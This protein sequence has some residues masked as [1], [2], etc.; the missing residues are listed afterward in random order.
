MTSVSSGSPH[1][2][3]YRRLKT[4]DSLVALGAPPP[5]AGFFLSPT[6]LRPDVC[7]PLSAGAAGTA[8]ICDN[9]TASTPVL[10]GATNSDTSRETYQRS[11]TPRYARLQSGMPCPSRRLYYDSSSTEQNT[12]TEDESIE[13]K[14]IVTRHQRA[15][16]RNSLCERKKHQYESS[17]LTNISLPYVDI[18]EKKVDSWLTGSQ[19]DIVL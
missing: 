16:C 1:M 11:L 15:E 10:Y 2:T 7:R 3:S 18:G 4:G 8:R 6:G 9:L 13:M 17:D 5:P 12:N 19:K 14:R